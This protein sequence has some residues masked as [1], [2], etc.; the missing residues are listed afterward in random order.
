MNVDVFH[1]SVLHT[2]TDQNPINIRSLARP[3]FSDPFVSPI[4]TL[5]GSS[6]TIPS[7]PSQIVGEM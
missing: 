4:V 5:M 6:Y 7:L 3:C 1:S 2:M